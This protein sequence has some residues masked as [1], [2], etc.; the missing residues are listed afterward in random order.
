ME[1]G[2]AMDEDV[3]TIQHTLV[4]R[5]VESERNVARFYALMIK[6]DLL[7]RTVLVQDSRPLLSQAR[8]SFDSSSW[9]SSAA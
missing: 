4:L 9:L 6:R 2:S 1:K 3:S 8:V 5:Q 7:G